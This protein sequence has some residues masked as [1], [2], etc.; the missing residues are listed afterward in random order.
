V[1]DLST[2]SRPGR[3]AMLSPPCQRQKLPWDAMG[4]DPYGALPHVPPLHNVSP[5]GRC[6]YGVRHNSKIEVC[7]K[8]SGVV[9]GRISFSAGDVGDSI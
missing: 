7:V 9:V 6:S 3:D 4:E 8:I 1:V 2:F 5:S